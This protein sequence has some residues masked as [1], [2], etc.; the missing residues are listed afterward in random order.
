M[1]HSDRFFKGKP[2]LNLNSKFNQGI[3]KPMIIDT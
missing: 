2:K 1:K 3:F